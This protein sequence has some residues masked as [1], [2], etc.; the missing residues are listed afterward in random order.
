MKSVGTIANRSGGYFIA[1]FNLV[2]SSQV[3]NAKIYFKLGGSVVAGADFN[4]EGSMGAKTWISRTITGPT[5]GQTLEI[6][7]FHNWSD[8]RTDILSD[9]GLTFTDEGG[10]YCDIIEISPA[11]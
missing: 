8:T 11:S 2:L 7:G 9:S 1:T 5:S 6:W 10:S 4:R 3:D